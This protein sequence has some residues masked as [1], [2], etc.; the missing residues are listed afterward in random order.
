MSALCGFDV[1]QGLRQVVDDLPQTFAPENLGEDL[2]DVPPAVRR[3]PA[4]KQ[5]ALSAFGSGTHAGQVPT[6]SRR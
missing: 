4:E 6:K 3:S 2:A 5:E 1:I